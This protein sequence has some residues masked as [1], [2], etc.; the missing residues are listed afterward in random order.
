MESEETLESFQSSKHWLL[1]RCIHVF[2]PSGKS[3]GK[4]AYRYRYR[5]ARLD[6]HVRQRKGGTPGPGRRA[7]LHLTV[8]SRNDHHHRWM[9]VGKDGA[10]GTGSADHR[11]GRL[12]LG[13][14]KG[15]AAPGR[16]AL[17]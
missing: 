10:E 17:V 13:V 9:A 15:D 16:G 11:Q 14:W 3:Y 12:K 8:S 2:T 4:P 6:L 1:H 5:R 7:H